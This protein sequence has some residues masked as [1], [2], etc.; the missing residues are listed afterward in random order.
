MFNKIS[1]PF[2]LAISFLS[3]F[4][5]SSNNL[6][7]QVYGNVN[8]GADRSII[9]AKSTADDVVGNPYLLETW[10]TGD[11]K[12]VDGNTANGV[13]LKYDVLEGVLVVK[14]PN[15][16]ENTFK[17]P[18]KEFTLKEGGKSRIFRN[19]FNIATL[20]GKKFA[21]VIYDGKSKFLKVEAKMIIESK[22]YNT[23]TIT[24]KIEDT[25][26]YFLIKQDGTP[27][28]VKNNEKSMLAILNRPELSKYIKDNNI[29]F[30]SEDDIAK[31][32]T[33]YDSLN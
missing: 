2:L 12:F 27:I 10:V 15:G 7:A 6:L 11:V 31:L 18:V 1:K 14:G 13:A 25:K 30:K 24:K 22:G 20:E 4:I 33:Y 8:M 32:L 16:E 21:E 26:S 3:F 19:G 28:L 17:D 23:G 5:F 9:R 29:S